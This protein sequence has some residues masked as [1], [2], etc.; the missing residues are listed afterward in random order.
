MR[1]CVESFVFRI[2]PGT[3]MEEESVKPQ[4]QLKAR[5]QLFSF[6]LVDVPG[7]VEE[8]TEYLLE[9]LHQTNRLL[10]VCLELALPTCEKTSPQLSWL[11]TVC[12][13]V[14]Q[15]IASSG[16]VAGFTRY[17]AD[18]ETAFKGYYEA[19]PALVGEFTLEQL[20]HVHRE[21][22]GCSLA[23]LLQTPL[24]EPLVWANMAARLR[25]KSGDQTLDPVVSFL[26]DVFARLC[27]LDE[28]AKS[29]EEQVKRSLE[30]ELRREKR[31]ITDIF[32]RKT[33]LS[34]SDGPRSFFGK[35]EGL[36]MVLPRRS[37][38]VRDVRLFLFHD[39][40]LILARDSP[41]VLFRMDP[42]H[43]VASAGHTP[44]VQEAASAREGCFSLFWDRG[45]GKVEQIVLLAGSFAN[46][47]RCLS[48]VFAASLLR[49]NAD[50]HK[51]L[52]LLVRER[53]PFFGRSSSLGTE[54]HFAVYAFGVGTV[55][56][57]AAAG[58][59]RR[60]LG[61]YKSRELE[62]FAP[63]ASD[64]HDERV[65]VQFETETFDVASYGAATVLTLLQAV[66]LH[67]SETEVRRTA[68]M[69]QPLVPITH[70]SRSEQLELRRKM[71]EDAQR[72]AVQFVQKQLHGR[73][74]DVQNEYN[75]LSHALFK[76]EEEVRELQTKLAEKNAPPLDVVRREM[77]PLE[78]LEFREQQCD[79]EAT[80]VDFS[81]SG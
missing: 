43:V 57:R 80:S 44:Y 67:R 50:R 73:L 48:R 79:N 72:K 2:H 60:V 3:A 17:L 11:Y 29:Q 10:A 58:P 63:L 15:E 38:V 24:A 70:L 59:E 5:A 52:A 65:R 74:G 18:I 61:T 49:L 1:W 64:H 16:A 53:K 81:E 30:A 62:S 22:E 8:E 42:Q 14:R 26:T 41:T 45:R 39:T 51:A 33:A 31:G 37:E 25:R 36:R 19:Y 27:L 12:Y 75:E 7:Q 76:R 20:A 40:I 21:A 23:L 13:N 69:R 55:T 35:M 56:R 34:L 6:L 46:C 66:A 9:H 47:H 54:Y 68:R 78:R 28:A 32:H 4:N 77:T 71:E